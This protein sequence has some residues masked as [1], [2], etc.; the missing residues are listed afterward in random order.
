METFLHENDI[1]LLCFQKGLPIEGLNKFFFP[2][3]L[4]FFEV[5]Y[6][7][8]YEQSSRVYYNTLHFDQI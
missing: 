1:I 6:N 7:I 2:I 5:S 4:E 3:G 8:C